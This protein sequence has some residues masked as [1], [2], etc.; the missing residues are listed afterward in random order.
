MTED[1]DRILRASVPERHKG[2][3]SPIGAVQSYIAELEQALKP[4]A[5]AGGWLYEQKGYVNSVIYKP[6]K[7]PDDDLSTDH[8]IK[9]FEALE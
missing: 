7:F 1:E 5:E 8:L 4:F 3:A 9:A 6:T 2:C